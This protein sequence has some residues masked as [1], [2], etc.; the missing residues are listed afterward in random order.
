MGIMATLM[1]AWRNNSKELKTIQIM[2]KCS[3]CDGNL[4]QAVG[5]FFATDGALG[6]AQQAD[7]QSNRAPPRRNRARAARAA[8]P[9]VY[10]FDVESGDEVAVLGEVRRPPERLNDEARPSN[11]DEEK[12]VANQQASQ[13][14]V[15]TDGVR[16]P[17]APVT[18]RLVGQ[19]FGQYYGG[20]FG[21]VS[22]ILITLFR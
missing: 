1:I 12:N 5:L 11:S 6:M 9:N 7:P 2:F 21:N 10:Q 14:P 3:V 16:N 20:L 8:R 18:G 19:T 15:D 22:S 17:I 4:E 13:N